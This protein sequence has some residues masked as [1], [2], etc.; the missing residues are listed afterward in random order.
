MLVVWHS[1][2]PTASVSRHAARVIVGYARVIDGDTIDVAG[3]RIRLHGIDAPESTQICVIDS[4]PYRCGERATLA[5]GD[6]VRGHTVR[7]DSMG[8][9]RYRRTLARCRLTENNLDIEGWLVRQGFA[10]AFRRYSSEYLV[11]EVLA[12][13]AN[14]GLWAG[15]FQ[16]PWD[17]RAETR[18]ENTR[19]SDTSYG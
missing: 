18:S 16:W 6:L 19:R 11:D 2:G 4:R 3:T 12:R 8:L 9:D 1:F 13:I 5:L 15:T 14:R 10:V 7:C 17:Y